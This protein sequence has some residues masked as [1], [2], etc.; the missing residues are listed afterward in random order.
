MVEGG[1]TEQGGCSG[2]WTTNEG[3]EGEEK[4]GVGCSLLILCTTCTV[5]P[6]Y[7]R[8]G[9]KRRVSTLKVYDWKVT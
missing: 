9:S 3:G 8:G 7:P 4:S 6:A 5:T 1:W 2:G